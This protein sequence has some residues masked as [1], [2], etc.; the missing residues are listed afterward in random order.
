M[1]INGDLVTTFATF[2]N[3]MTPT[4]TQSADVSFQ[5]FGG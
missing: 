3:S 5:I 2:S 1:N 4:N